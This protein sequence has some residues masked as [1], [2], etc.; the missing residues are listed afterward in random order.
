MRTTRKKYFPITRTFILLVIL[1]LLIA[2]ASWFFV[3][4]IK[5][6]FFSQ[7][8]I[9]NRS[10]VSLAANIVDE[11]INARL[12]RLQTIAQ[13]PYSTKTHN[14]SENN[15]IKR[16]NYLKSEAEQMGYFGISLTDLEGNSISSNGDK[17]NVADND[18]FQKA[19]RGFTSVSNVEFYH[20]GWRNKKT[21]VIFQV[22]DF[23]GAEVKG[24]L[25]AAIDIE[26]LSPILE[27]IDIPYSDASLFIVDENYFVI[28]DTKNH[29]YNSPSLLR[30]SNYFSSAEKN[31]DLGINA[32]TGI[33]ISGNFYSSDNNKNKQIMSFADL[34]STGRWKLLAVSSKESILSAQRNIMLMSGFLILFVVLL[35]IITVIYLYIISWKYIRLR[36][37]SNAAMYKS[38]VHLFMM[39]ELGEATDFDIDFT[40]FLGL[41][42]DTLSFNFVQFMK[43][44]QTVFPLDSI[45]KHDSFRFPFLTEDGRHIHLLIQ[46]IGDNEAGFYPSFAID[47]TNNE[48]LQERL[49]VLAYTD[50]TTNIPNRESFILMVEELNKKCL[51]EPFKSCFLFID[52]N[53]SY[54]ILEIFGHR[55]FQLMLREAADRL[56]L[57]AEESGAN[58]Y[59][60]DNDDFVL[61]IANYNEMDEIMNIVCAVKKIFIT[62]FTFGDA[63]FDIS[64]RFG[65]VSCP[66][67]LIQTQIPPSDMFRY[68]EITVRLAKT[69]NNL[70][71]LN[72]ETYLSVINELDIE[73]DLACSIRNNE[74]V[75]NYQPIYDSN[76]DRITGVEAL[77]RWKS[78][79]HGNVPPNIFIPIAEKNGFINQLGDFVIGSV[80]D[81]AERIN[82][83]NIK[84]NFNVSSMQFIQSDFVNKLIT[85]FQT[86]NLPPQSIGLELTESCLCEHI[87]ELSE[88]LKLIRNAG[89][90]VSIDD[91]GTGYSSLSYLKDLP[92]D[93]LK[94]DRSF[95]HGIESSEKQRIIINS[96][97]SLAEALGTHVVAEGVET[98]KE[99][100]MVLKSSCIL[101]QGY[102]IAK[103][104][105]EDETLEF[106]DAF[107]GLNN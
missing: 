74:L 11:R 92:I 76:D 96:L 79:K 53:K 64:C 38:G 83:K 31:L 46:I 25:S 7:A 73:R 61:V 29:S 47:V 91:F 45:K 16:L 32:K 60:L 36:G 104:M 65:V 82:G 86:L 33:K 14:V 57:I 89:I 27:G 95:I 59:N 105:P 97:S 103:P 3:N 80:M 56:S 20:P 78:P 18:Q 102:L 90:T 63:L 44:G 43:E 8:D 9:Q 84:V 99:L 107:K 4:H 42:E 23:T 21:A 106:I 62:P 72:M 52:I 34:P 87:Y 37:I 10:M 93:H 77:L 26:A 69:N 101:I 67:Y 71:V 75:L 2:F 58:I 98:Q 55:L 54:K 48:I 15:T 19:L 68:G 66:E 94:I 12:M 51:K 13:T 24:S 50:L 22:P 40:K 35:I 17:Y 30:S 39:S 41:N 100:E 88:K 1:L 6:L 81:L 28:A 70:F 49:Q 85:K 5:F